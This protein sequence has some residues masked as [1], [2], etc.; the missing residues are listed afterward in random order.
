MPT[1]TVNTAVGN[2]SP[3][4]KQRIAQ[5]LTRIHQEVTG[6]QKFFAQVIF[7]EV[8]PSDYFIGGLPLKSKNIFINA[9]IRAGRT[10]EQTKELISRMVDSV[11]IEASLPK[12]SI[13]IYFHMMPPG[14]MAE[15]GVVL[16]EPG[17]ENSWLEN[18]PEESR[19]VIEAIGT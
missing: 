11:A 17:E 12:H 19:G 6:A 1:Y 15:F 2:L 4:V 7:N 13:W 9:Q 16:P 5:E 14:Q 18:L 10:A 3:D 8:S